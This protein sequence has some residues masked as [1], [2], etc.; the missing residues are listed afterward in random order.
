MLCTRFPW[1][2][3]TDFKPDMAWGIASA[4]A[5]IAT[6]HRPFLQASRA[7]QIGVGAAWGAA[8]LIKSPTFR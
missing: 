2:C 4:A 8:L 7:R 6:L 5:V 1:V 3:I